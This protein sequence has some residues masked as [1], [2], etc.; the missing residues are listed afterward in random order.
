MLKDI[1]SISGK[2][3]LYKLISYGK[4]MVIVEGLTDKKRFPAYAHNKI[5]SLG[6]IAMYT[7]SGEVQLGEV[8]D[9]VY[10][11]H[12]GNQ[13]DAKALSSN[14]ALKAFFLEVMPDYDQER[15]YTNDIKKVVAW[16]NLLVGVGFTKFSSEEVAEEET[17]E[18]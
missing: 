17:S 18:E 1:L 4:N 8:F 5:I 10:A 12:E 16:Y 13:L 14:D 15:V 7:Y 2:P 11:K 9:K 6:D 3:G